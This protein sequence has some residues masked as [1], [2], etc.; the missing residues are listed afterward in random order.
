QWHR[1]C[2]AK[3]SEKRAS[4]KIPWTVQTPRL[5]ER[6]LRR[7]A[8]QG[9]SLPRLVTRPGCGWMVSSFVT[10]R[11]LTRKSLI[12]ATVMAFAVPAFAQQAEPQMKHQDTEVYAPIPPTVTPGKTDADPPSAPIILFHVKK[13]NERGRAENHPPPRGAAAG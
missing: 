13:H 3:F 4:D 11:T 12:V 8:N 7:T 10:M 2:P 5:E 1:E 9:I 6:Q